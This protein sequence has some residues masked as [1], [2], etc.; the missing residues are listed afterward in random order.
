M[1]TDPLVP[2]SPQQLSTHCFDALGTAWSIST[3]IELPPAVLARLHRRVEDFDL[4]YSRFRPDSLIS[5]LAVTGGVCE[6]PEDAAPLLA[7]YRKLYEITAGRVSPLVGNVLV[8]LGYDADYSLRRRPGHTSAPAW[9]DVLSVDGSVLTASEPV[10]LDLGAA[11]KGYL[12]DL[13]AEILVDAGF[14]EYLIDGS[15]D[16]AR[17]GPDVCR[18]G[19]EHPA[20][21]CKA[22]GVANLHN[23]VLCGSATNRRSWGTGLHHIIDPAT[24]EPTTGIEATW[25]A[26]ARGPGRLMASDPAGGRAVITHPAMVADGLATALFLAEPSCL[27]PY[28]DFTYVRMFESGAVDHSADFDGELFTAAPRTGPN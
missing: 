17:S 11:G 5:R 26:T 9:D 8:H 12:V 15:G 2:T 21:P 18:V 4:A 16:I 1:A 7:F 19:L 14:A 23:G 24:G 28:F 25:V 10:L 22:I 6:L 3:P 13:L 20:D 27:A